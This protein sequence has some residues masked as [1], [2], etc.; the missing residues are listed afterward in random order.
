MTSP[1]LW[2]AGRFNA[3]VLGE[4]LMFVTGTFTR[5]ARL[6]PAWIFM[7]LSALTGSVAAAENESLSA[8]ELTLRAAHIGTDGPSLLQFFRRLIP[9]GERFERIPPLIRLLGHESFTIR[10]EATVQLVAIGPAAAPRLRQAAGDP[11][12]EIRRRAQHCLQQLA[13]TPDRSL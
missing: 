12:P 4:L 3:P 1:A 13:R 7:V 6:R 9:R 10:E 8:D 2:R 5:P 11:D